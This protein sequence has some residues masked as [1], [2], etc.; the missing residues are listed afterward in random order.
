M[1]K[2]RSSSKN[3]NTFPKDRNPAEMNSTYYKQED[4]ASFRYN[5]AL[6]IL[7]NQGFPG[8]KGK[9]DTYQAAHFFIE[10]ENIHD[11]IFNEDC[12]SI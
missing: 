9:K 2:D 4:Q 11:F 5:P 6:L 3:S 10:S 7:Q 1:K 12:F 8:N